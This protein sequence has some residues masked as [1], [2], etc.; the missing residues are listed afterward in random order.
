MT[1]GDDGDQQVARE[2]GT[3]GVD[4]RQARNGGLTYLHMPARDP[5]RSAD[6]YERV[7]GWT[8]DRREEG[9]ASFSDTT[10]NVYGAWVTDQAIARE[11]GLLP[12]IYVDHIEE[13]LR[14]L[15]A[16]GGEVVTPAYREGNLWVATFHDPAGNVLGVWQDATR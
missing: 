9:R 7:F 3:T 4:A 1:Q 15:V 11:P 10:G 16:E 8:V 14:Q 12:Y 6:F 5:L 13:T 2:G